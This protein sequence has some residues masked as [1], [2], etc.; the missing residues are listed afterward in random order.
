MGLYRTLQLTLTATGDVVYVND[1]DILKVIT[2]SLGAKVIYDHDGAGRRDIVVL[3]TPAQ[4]AVLSDL[5][6]AVTES[7]V[8]VYLSTEHIIAISNEPGGT[9]SIIEYD[10]KG[11]VREVITVS[12]TKGALYSTIQTL[13]GATVYAVDD[14]SLTNN[15]ISLAAAHGNVTANFAAGVVLTVSAST[16]N[17]GTYTTTS[18]AFSG[19]KTVITITETIPDSTNDGSVVQYGT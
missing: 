17:D 16:G 13:N 8:T 5:L 9:G 7:S 18:S 6:F 2:D 1:Q 12:E 10:N 15:T 11:T 4:I 14:V 19:G 3:E